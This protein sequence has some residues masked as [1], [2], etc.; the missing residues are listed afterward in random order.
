MDMK[1]VPVRLSGNHFI[2]KMKLVKVLDS[3]LIYTS[4]ISGCVSNT[5]LYL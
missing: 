1:S 2:A 5:F 3:L 4:V